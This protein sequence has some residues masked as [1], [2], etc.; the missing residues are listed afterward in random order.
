MKLRSAFATIIVL[1]SLYTA[2][3]QSTVRIERKS[4]EVYIAAQSCD[5]QNYYYRLYMKDFES[6]PKWIPT[7]KEPPLSIGEAIRS[8]TRA[9]AELLGDAETVGGAQIQ[10][11]ELRKLSRID[12]WY[13]DVQFTDVG[14]S[15]KW[16]PFSIVVRMD[17]VALSPTTF[18]PQ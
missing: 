13:Y 7:E 17:G 4:N 18:D 9:L 15:R 2:Y 6:S 16:S 5:G 14:K 11:V 10:A 8:A 3:A 1:G 12:H